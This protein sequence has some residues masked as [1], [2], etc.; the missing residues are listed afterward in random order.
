MD[1]SESLVLLAR[2]GQEYLP[3]KVIDEDH[4]Q[5]FWHPPSMQ[6]LWGPFSSSPLEPW[7]A[8]RWSCY[9]AL[10]QYKQI[11]GEPHLDVIFY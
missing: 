4:T 3:Q 2:R 1:F 7:N 8:L 11:A 9:A 5:S 6:Y 10:W